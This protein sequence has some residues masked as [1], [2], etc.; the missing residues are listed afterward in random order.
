MQTETQTDH[1]SVDTLYGGKVTL[2]QRR[3]GYRFTA[4]AVLLAHSA[5]G[6]RGDVIDLG[7]GCGIVPVVLGMFG[8]AGSVTGLE[9]QEGLASIASRNVL[10]NG[11]AGKVRIVTGDIR[12]VRALFPP[13]LYDHVVSNPPY[14]PVDEGRINPDSEKA[15]ARHEVLCSIADVVAAASYLLRGRGTFRI[16]YPNMRLVELLAM[17]RK[18]G[19]EPR[20]MRFVH[21]RAADP[22][23]VSVI[24]AVKGAGPGMEIGPPIVFREPDG[25]PTAEY[26]KIFDSP[27]PVAE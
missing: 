15:A 18:G 17:M 7:T 23:K 12:G 13:Q 5:L 10:T 20:R 8:K 11:L 14:Q 25:R 21:D 9:I 16:I 2:S 22:S 26:V 24:E 4:D 1:E 19:L 27:E 6:V 3:R